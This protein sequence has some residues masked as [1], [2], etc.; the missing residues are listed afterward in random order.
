[1]NKKNNEL[2]NL[3]YTNKADVM[4][5]KS[6]IFTLKNEYKTYQCEA[7]NE[8]TKS[9]MSVISG[10]ANIGAEIFPPTGIQKK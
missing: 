1:M 3:M 8:S 10:Q 4:M 6:K 2:A 7:I 5:D 9:I